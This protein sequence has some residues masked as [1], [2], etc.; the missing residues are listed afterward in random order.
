MT[1]GTGRSP[2]N[3]G[4]KRHV[5]PHV[6]P[7][8]EPASRR[9]AAPRRRCLAAS[10]TAT[11]K[12][13]TPSP[14]CSIRSTATAWLRPTTSGTTTP[15]AAGLPPVETLIPTI[16]PLGTLVPADGAWETT[17]PLG[18]AEGTCETLTRKPSLLSVVV[19]DAS[20]QASHRRDPCRAWP[21]DTVS[22]TIEP[23][24]ACRP[25]GG[26]WLITRPF[27]CLDAA[28]TVRP[29]KPADW[30]RM[31][32]WSG[33]IR[34]R[35][36]P[37]PSSARAR[38]IPSPGLRARARFRAPGSGRALFRAAPHCSHVLERSPRSPL[39]ELLVAAVVLRPTT[40]GTSIFVRRASIVSA[41]E[42]ARPRSRPR[43]EPGAA[44]ARPEE[45]PSG[46]RAGP[47]LAS[48][49]RVE[50]SR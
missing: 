20:G 45:R 50:T 19:A 14:A 7:A 34:R 42:R 29:F 8:P 5:D 49:R 17:T 1:S 44:R 2:A 16:D 24:F 13:S 15:P 18:S 26:A 32:A 48:L 39:R 41:Q 11:G 3:A 6:R 46:R 35:S 31:K 12:E 40:S 27:G 37:R 23:F 28:S 43:R 33:P 25:P 30:S 47:S 4:T 10:S 21:L 36:A 22:T 38:R 9:P